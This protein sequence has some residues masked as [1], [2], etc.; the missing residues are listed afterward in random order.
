MVRK[1]GRCRW[2]QLGEAE[3]KM[4]GAKDGQVGEWGGEAAKVV[5]EINL[6]AHDNIIVVSLQVGMADVSKCGTS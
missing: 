3:T 4:M 1:Y 2:E 6:L 5:I